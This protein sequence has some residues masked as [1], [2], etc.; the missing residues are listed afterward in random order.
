M[1]IL[2]TWEIAERQHPL[3]RALTLLASAEPGESRA[4]LADLPLAE[5][6]RRL[7]NLREDLF[8]HQIEAQVT[9]P[10]CAH[11][12][13]FEC[14]VADLR[15]VV[16]GVEKNWAAL[17]HAGRTLHFRLPSSR[18]LAA[19][20]ELHD[21]ENARRQLALRCLVEP[22]PLSEADLGNFFSAERLGDL[23][24]QMTQLHPQAETR[25]HFT[26]PE[27]GKAWSDV[28]DV[29][30]FLWTELAAK[31]RQ[32]LLEVDALART[33]GWSEAEV[34]RLSPARRAAYLKLAMT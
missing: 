29:A 34:L 12:L 24:R 31:A 6:D 18:D 33:Y 15:S 1:D 25:L 13:T 14:R 2:T 7:W 23:G 17:E 9:C 4:T 19:V 22:T 3:D 10:H 21:P 16:P 11:S 20:A 26:C 30:D 28:L 27:C 5:R 8:G 32:L